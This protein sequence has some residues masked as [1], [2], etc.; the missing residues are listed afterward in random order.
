MRINKDQK[1]EINLEIIKEKIY[2][3]LYDDG[4]FIS[5][6][7]TPTNAKEL[8]EELIKLSEKMGE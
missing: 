2:L 3:T 8:G 1:D 4:M 7:L 6:I 5:K